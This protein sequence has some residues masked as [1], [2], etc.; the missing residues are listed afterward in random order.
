MRKN[1]E[2]EPSGRE[3]LAD[4]RIIQALLDS[5]QIGRPVSV[6]PVD[7]WRRPE[8]RQEIE[9]PPVSKPQLVRAAAP[10]AE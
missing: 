1:K 2:P 8:M 4:V 9:K 3:G 5:A 7:V 10:G 6:T